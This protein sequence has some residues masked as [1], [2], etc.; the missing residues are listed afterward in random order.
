MRKSIN[1][2]KITLNSKVI[3]LGIIFYLILLLS[4]FL[5][6]KLNPNVKE[7]DLKISKIED[8][9]EK[10]LNYKEAYVNNVESVSNSTSNNHNKSNRYITIPSI[11]MY[12][13]EI[14]EGVDQETLKNNVGHF[15][16]SADFN[17]NVCLAAHNYS[18]YTSDL[19]KNLHTLKTGDKII[20]SFNGAQRKY[21]VKE[22]FEVASNDFSVL[23]ETNENVITCITCTINNDKNKRLCLRAVEI[24]EENK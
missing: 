24:K 17:G 23:E 12:N 14:H 1:L 6:L 5:I 3:I 16:F 7:K 18:V 10:N 15:I 21:A 2:K 8:T 19:F 20:Y 11:N 9:K 4:I 22:I 13:E